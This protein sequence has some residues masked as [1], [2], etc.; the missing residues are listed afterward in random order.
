[1]VEIIAFR[2]K[3]PYLEK[4]NSNVTIID[5]NTERSRYVFFKLLKILQDKKF[6]HIISAM[7]DSNILLG[8]I[9]YF[10]NHN[11]IFREANTMNVTNSLPFFK[12]NLFKFLMRISYKNANKIIANSQ[13]TMNDLLANNIVKSDVNI[14]VIG[15]PVLPLDIENLLNK[16]IEHRWFIDQDIKVILSVGRLVEQKNYSLLIKAFSKSFEKNKSLRLVILGEGKLKNV[17]LQ[18]ASKLHLNDYV[19]IIS[20]QAN[21]YPYFSKSDLFVLSSNWEGFGN[22]IVESMASKTPVVCTDCIGGPK[23]ILKNGKYGDLIAVNNVDELSI[24]IL[25][26]IENPNFQRIDL[27]KEESLNYSVQSIAQEYIK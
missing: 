24:A 15:N 12:K 7:R 6:N 14:Q 11:M 22:V 10:Q 2:A 18:L 19:E 17:L 5:L 1:E 26:N 21:P 4:I 23:M 13:D 9:G 25:V 27:A 3:G 20:F 8:L 16:K